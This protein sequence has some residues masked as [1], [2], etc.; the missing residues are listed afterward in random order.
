MFRSGCQK[1][2]H[3]VTPV[4]TIKNNIQNCT[5]LRHGIKMLSLKSQEAVST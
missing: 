1:Y 3:C 5:D 2:V 4:L